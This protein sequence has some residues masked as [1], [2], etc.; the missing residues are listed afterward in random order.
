MTAVS[1]A[2]TFERFLGRLHGAEPG[3]MLIVCGGMHGNEPAGAL[4]A[5]D[6]VESLRRRGVAIRGDIVAVAGNLEAM[7]EDRRFVHHD[8]NRAWTETRIR[9]LLA[10]EPALDDSEQREQRELFAIFEEQRAM[11][12]GQTV[13]VDLHTTSAG[14]PPFCIFSDTLA[15]RAV[16]MPLGVPAILGLEECIDGTLLDYATKAG[17]V[18]LVVE[19][20]QHRDPVSQRYHEA[21]LWVTL[22]SL[23]IVSEGD[24]PDLA[25]HRRLLGEATRS[26]PPVV[27]VRYR[28]PVRPGDGF[29]MRPGYVGFQRIGR[30]EV[31]AHDRSGEIR[32]RETGRILMPLYQAQGDDG[33]FVVRRIRPFWLGVSTWARRVGL[34]GIV[35][36]LPGVRRHPE[37]PDW[38]VVR[39]SVARFYRSQVFHLLGFRTREESDDE[40]VFARRR[41]RP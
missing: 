38:V 41:R 17:M 13:I 1:T 31:L 12:R 35:P 27:E 36:W 23:G 4:A 20:G 6:V 39:R 21:A 33:F 37:R 18:A 11:A 9:E 29:T 28:H 25:A 7:A 26:V 30:G 19:G 3:P 24:V 2:R 22:L 15:N 10:Q 14:G 34:P 8:L 40:V 16:A 5:R 32:A